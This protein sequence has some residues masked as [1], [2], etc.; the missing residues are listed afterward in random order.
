MSNT[1]LIA[2]ALVLAATSGVVRQIWASPCGAPTT[3]GSQCRNSVRCQHRYRFGA[4]LLR[5]ILRIAATGIVV[6][7]SGGIVAWVMIA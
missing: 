7:V 6:I 5:Y 4:H 1:L 3:T 2:A